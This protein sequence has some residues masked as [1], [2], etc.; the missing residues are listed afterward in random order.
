[1]WQVTLMVGALV[2]LFHI[3]RLISLSEPEVSLLRK[4]IKIYYIVSFSGLLQTSS[5]EKFFKTGT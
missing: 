1:M 4:I 5:Y 2:S 3:H